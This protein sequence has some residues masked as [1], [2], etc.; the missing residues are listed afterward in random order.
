MPSYSSKKRDY[1]L[2]FL[3]SCVHGGR[4]SGGGG[5]KREGKGLLFII[6]KH[7]YSISWDNSG[8]DNA[9]AEYLPMQ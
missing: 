3:W 8:I 4:E 1:F 9:M 5:V 2:H 7:T 6:L